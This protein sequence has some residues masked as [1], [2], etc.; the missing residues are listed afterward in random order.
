MTSPQFDLTSP[1]VW[2]FLYDESKT[3]QTPG[4]G[5]FVPIPRVTLPI[6]LQEKVLVIGTSATDTKPSWKSAGSVTQRLLIPGLGQSGVDA[7]R[8][9]LRLNALTLLI[10]PVLTPDYQL[11]IDVRP[12]LRNLD[13]SV[14]RYTG[15]EQNDIVELI[16]TLKIDV[17]RVEA[18]IDSLS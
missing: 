9:N 17:L 10:F 13:I 16:Q 4:P 18:K 7:T 8:Q 1:G 11:D 5:V 3:A 15:P 6:I 12:W 2:E 14:W